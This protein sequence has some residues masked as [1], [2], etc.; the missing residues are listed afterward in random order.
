[1]LRSYPERTTLT[2]QAALLESDACLEADDKREEA[3]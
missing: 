1:M 3:Q 2:R